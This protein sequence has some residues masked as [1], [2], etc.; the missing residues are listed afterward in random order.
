MKASVVPRLPLLPTFFM[1]E[2][3]PMVA[4]AIQRMSAPRREPVSGELPVNK[5][6]VSRWF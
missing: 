2:A 3:S 6:Q 1:L 5:T 4:D